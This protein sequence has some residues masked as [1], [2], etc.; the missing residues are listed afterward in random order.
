MLL[1]QTK[2]SPITELALTRKI[3]RKK[4]TTAKHIGKATDQLK[5]SINH[6]YSDKSIEVITDGNRRNLST[7]SRDVFGVVIVKEV[8]DPERPTCSPLVFSVFE[9]TGI[10][11]LLLDYAEFQQLTFFRPTEE[12]LVRTLWEIFSVACEHDVFPRNRFGLRAGDTVVYQPRETGKASDSTTDESVHTVADRGQS[13]A[14]PLSWDWVTSDSARMGFRKGSGADWLRVVVDRT[15]VEALDVSRPASLLSRVLANRNA[16]EQHRARV[17]FSFH[18]YS[19]DP[20]ELY[21]NPG[22]AALLHETG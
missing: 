13:I 19:S 18:G 15:E 1:I 5:G 8:F 14:A 22:S 6:L 11:C 10:P 16:V 3:V 17:D 4:A 9:E 7:S 2:D 21:E 20:R 12:S